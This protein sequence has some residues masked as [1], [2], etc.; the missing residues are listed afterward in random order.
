MNRTAVVPK[1][2][3]ELLSPL[4][5]FRLNRPVLVLKALA[6]CVDLGVRH[7]LN[8]TFEVLKVRWVHYG[9][10]LVVCMNRP[11]TVLIANHQTR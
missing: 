11:F 3:V 7:R 10:R 9:P 1:A 6:L 5:F 8:R 4:G 2:L